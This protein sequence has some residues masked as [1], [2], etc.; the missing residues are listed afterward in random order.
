M[1]NIG[2][3]DC[4]YL[5]QSLMAALM[6][7]NESTFNG[8]FCAI[9]S[10]SRNAY[11]QAVPFLSFLLGL[12]RLLVM[13]HVD[14]L[15]RTN[16]LFMLSILTSWLIYPTFIVLHFAVPHVSFDFDP[17]Y[18]SYEYNFPQNVEFLTQIG[19]FF[20]AITFCCY[21]GILAIII[22][23]KRL[24]STVSSSSSTSIQFRILFQAFLLTIPVSFLNIS[25]WR[26][27]FLIESN[28][29]FEILWQSVAAL[30]P[31][32][33]LL[34]LVVFNPLIRGYLSKL[35]SRKTQLRKMFVVRS[36]TYARKVSSSAVERI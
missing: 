32:I 17:S 16:L 8:T 21:L 15:K 26:L 31:G 9:L 25:G 35:V 18:G 6:T 20:A 4:L 1:L 12:N 19:L 23:R 27:A 2:L 13:L 10:S 28:E 34:V 29:F 3:M 14:T 5:F 11:L 7:L 33:H 36:W 22:A 30:L 24:L